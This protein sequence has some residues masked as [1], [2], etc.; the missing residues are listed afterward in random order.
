ML[1]FKEL[2]FCQKVGIGL[3]KS[4]NFG[5]LKFKHDKNRPDLKKVIIW[6]N[7][8]MTLNQRSTYTRI[9]KVNEL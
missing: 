2:I 5:Q 7:D 1:N 9:Y 8:F 6:I 4:N 3:Y